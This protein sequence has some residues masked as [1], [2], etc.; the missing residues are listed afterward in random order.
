LKSTSPKKICDGIRHCWDRSDEDTHYCGKTIPEEL[1]FKCGDSEFVIPMEMVCDQRL[2]CPNGADEMNCKK[3]LK[4]TDGFG[5]VMRRSFGV[6]YS[7]CF[8]KSTKIDTESIANELCN[9]SKISARITNH[10][11]ND[12][13]HHLQDDIVASSSDHIQKSPAK[14]VISE[15]KFSAVK[16]NDRFTVHLRSD[17]PLTKIVEWDED[18]HANC[19]RLEVKCG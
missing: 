1:S 12:T 18:D 19:H 7:E 8:P 15:T 13:H 3:I 2:D 4:S 14:K 16:I 11:V 17:R 5:E 10:N 6:W 9:T